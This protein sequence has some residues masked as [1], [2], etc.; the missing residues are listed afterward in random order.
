MTHYTSSDIR[1][2]LSLYYPSIEYALMFEV[3]NAT[4][5]RKT[6][7]ADAIAMNLWP[8]RGLA[9]NGIEIKVNRGDWLREKAN[10]LKAEEIAQFCDFWWIAAPEGVV[11]AD[12]L[13]ETWGWL[14]PN[15]NS[16]KIKKQAVKNP[17]AKP[18]TRNFVAGMARNLGNMDKADVEAR[19]KVL[20]EAKAKV[21][22]ESIERRIKERTYAYD[23]L[24]K[25]V[26]DFEQAS[27]IKLD[28]Y[29][30]GKEMGEQL[31][32][33]QRLNANSSW[34]SIFGNIKTLKRELELIEADLL[35]AVG[36]TDHQKADQAAGGLGR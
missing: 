13:P 14:I 16:M 19:A 31:K 20:L 26:S 10:P 25:V 36:A 17:E 1:A 21:L 32:L 8:S 27:G 23:D 30:N 22:E 35:K 24:Q 34:G 15:G 4:G 2:R 29:C 5:G 6:R 9:I 28:Q 11:N 3:A 12:E 33:V 7:S 18:P